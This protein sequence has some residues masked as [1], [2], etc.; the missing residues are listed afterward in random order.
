MANRKDFNVVVVGQDKVLRTP[1][2]SGILKGTTVRRVMDL[3]R[4]HLL[5]GSGG[6][7]PA[8]LAPSSASFARAPRARRPN[9][10]PRAVALT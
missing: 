8:S 5:C 2:F 10:R 1:P 4:E 9:A 7:R 3:A 6:K